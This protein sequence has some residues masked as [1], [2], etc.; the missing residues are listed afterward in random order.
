MSSRIIS[1]SLTTQNSVKARSLPS[2]S[3]G[4]VDPRM[5]SF[6]GV[7][8]LALLLFGAVLAFPEFAQRHW[9]VLW[10]AA[11]GLGAGIVVFFRR[12]LRADWLHPAVVYMIIFWL[13]HFG[14]VFPAAL[15]PDILFSMAP[16][17]YQYFSR[18]EAGTAVIAALLFMAFFAWGASLLSSPRPVRAESKKRFRTPELVLGGWAMIL[19]GLGILV[20][21]VITYGIQVFFLPY[22][23]YI[24]I[25][26][27]P[28]YAIINIAFGLILL[29]VGG[30]S[31]RTVIGAGLLTYMPLFLLTMASG[32]RTGPLFSLV[33]II[34]ILSMRGIRIPRVWLAV[35]ALAVLVLISTIRDV[36]SPGLAGARDAAGSISIGDPMAGMTELGSSI[37]P[38][39]VTAEFMRTSPY[40]YGSSYV[41]PFYRQI[42]RA[43][44][45]D[46]GSPE[47]DA[48]FI[49]TYITSFYGSI[50]FSTVAEAYANGGLAGVA[51]FAVLWGLALGWL[52][53]KAGT[54]YGAAFLAAVLI[55]MMSNIRNSF[56]YVPAWIFFG[57]IPLVAMKILRK[58]ISKR[59]SREIS[60]ANP[61]VS[62][63]RLHVP[64]LGV[65]G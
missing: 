40:L 35:G 42:A 6:Y 18:P 64:S 11:G 27:T 24:E 29:A 53:R 57:A 23:D 45:R 12:G 28:T 55:P 31:V 13:F 43:I 50:G 33:V 1:R 65:K 20:S 58:G 47:T 37:C 32:S 8:V 4:S 36:R 59:R 52:V 16:W 38:V 17:Y 19:L 44:G 15:D 26:N 49:A 22:S 10:F 41:Y 2:R 25:S 14:L 7:L 9:R 60:E 54:P 61:P 62:E 5:M 21:F 63:A 56:I 3:H 46:P 48:R 39:I 34:I 30:S 51:I